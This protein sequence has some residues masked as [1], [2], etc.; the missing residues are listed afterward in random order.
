MARKTVSAA[1]AHLPVDLGE[2]P[3][4][5]YQAR[6][7]AKESSPSNL[8][9]LLELS[10]NARDNATDV[11]LTIDVA[12]SRREKQGWVLVPKRVVCEDN[13]TGLTHAEFL[14]R[15]CGAYSESEAHHE[16]DRAGRNGVGTKTYT[17]IA[18]RVKVE[19]TTARATQGLDAHRDLVESEL[20]E[21]VVLPR[22][23]E[24]DT[25][26]RV[27]EFQLHKRSA[28]PQ[29]WINVDPVEMGTRVELYELKAGTQITFEILRE[30]L[31]YTREWLQNPSNTF[32]L[33]LTGNVP[34]ELNS[35]KKTVLRPWSI[36]V[37]NW[38]VEARGRS[39]EQVHIYDPNTHQ[40]ETIPAAADLP[41]VLEFDFRVVGRN[42][43]GQ[44]QSLE[45]PA[46]I[47][48]VSGALPYA[49]NLEGVMSA[50]T[51][52]FL[53]F[54]D[55]EHASSIGAFYNSVCGW[56]RINSL[57]LKEC[58]R[59]NKTTLA[60]GPGADAVA[61]LQVYLAS[62]F[63]IL[64][65]GWYAA[66]RSSQDEAAQDALKEAQEEVNLA[67]KGPNR[68]PFKGGEIPHKNPEKVNDVTPPPARRHRWECGS[69]E[70]RWLAE[71]GFTPARCAE[72]SLSS[73]QGEGCGSTNIGLAKNQPRIADCEIRIEQLGDQRLP[74]VFQFERVDE[75]LD[76][77]VVRVNLSSP[78]YIELRGTGSMSG[79]A[80]QR[81][82]QYLVDVALVAIG[83]YNARTRGT[84]FSEEWG[85]LYF[86]RM[87][88]LTGIKKYQSQLTKLMETSS[89]AAEQR[90][91]IDAVAN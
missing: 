6:E 17:S 59:N 58:L 83:E 69:C 12:E 41:G 24:A 67:L 74:A 68:S 46:L 35:Q 39:D 37:K 18:D 81:L 72:R 22:D 25:V 38:L 9:V 61:A 75:D 66:T 64:H 82:K 36:P 77:P 86:N 91:L 89:P 57:A 71:A 20:T 42:N 79:Q 63:R 90:E 48:E 47:L 80:Q 84:D 30:R 15:F 65:R 7:Y 34:A 11:T 31:S 60:S 40:T 33:V 1:P 70:K 76:V 50:R 55:M 52:P 73:G 51:Q 5:L 8:A 4:N 19:T 85:D 21:G 27:Y 2:N 49:P 78:R 28:V 43:D 62:I 29:E 56:A 53:H 3:V 32:T 10:E 14:E 26:R 44:M 23:G 16:V 45:K 87:L 13:G 88:R 54:I